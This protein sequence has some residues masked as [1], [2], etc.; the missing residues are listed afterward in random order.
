MLDVLSLPELEQLARRTMPTVAYEYVAAGA[1]DEHTVRWNTE[2]FARLRL[3]P[4]ALDDVTTIDTR[5]T[6]FGDAL[7]FPILLAPVAYHRALH[8]EGELATA[9]GAGA[10]GAVWVVS[11]ATTTPIEEIARAATGPLWWQIYAQ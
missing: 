4:R 7:A 9:R 1:A 6:L 8:A 10:A 2:A 3:R 5:L 11:T